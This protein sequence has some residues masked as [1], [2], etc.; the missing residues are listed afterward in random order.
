MYHSSFWPRLDFY[1]FL[2]KLPDLKK[3]TSTHERK[4]QVW[5]PDTIVYN[6]PGLQ[7]YW[8]YTGKDGI[9]WKTEDFI[10]KDIVSKMANQFK[11]D[12]LVCVA[13]CVDWDA[14]NGVKKA[15]V[16]AL[17]ARDMTYQI[18]AFT[19]CGSIVVL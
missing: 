9:V 18:P 8:V 2:A 7:P 1:K 11:L 3:T 19:S 4:L 15:T 12:E 13:K 16:T 17:N 6:D 10:D 14:G 5:L